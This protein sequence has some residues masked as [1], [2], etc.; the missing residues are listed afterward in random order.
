M[1]L[2]KGQEKNLENKNKDLYSI[3]QVPGTVQS[4]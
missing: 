2:S 3:D 1:E 4:A